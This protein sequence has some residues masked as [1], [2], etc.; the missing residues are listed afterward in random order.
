MKTGGKKKGDAVDI[1]TAVLLWVPV[2]GSQDD[3]GQMSEVGVGT[4]ALTRLVHGVGSAECAEA[5][6]DSNGPERRVDRV[7]VP[8]CGDE[9]GQTDSLFGA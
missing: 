3:L 8:A 2:K 7:G 9:A 5:D 4:T 6:A 1:L